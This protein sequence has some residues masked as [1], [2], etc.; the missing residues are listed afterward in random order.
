MR[1]GTA[2]AHRMANR[3]LV[4]FEVCPGGP[5]SISVPPAGPYR[6]A[7]GFSVCW[8]S[9]PELEAGDA[10]RL[11]CPLPESYSWLIAPGAGNWDCGEPVDVSPNGGLNLHP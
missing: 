6:L 1:P 2:T 9:A 11:L 8:L 7:G 10:W 3:K 5:P 4:Q